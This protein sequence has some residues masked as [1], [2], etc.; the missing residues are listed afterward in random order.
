VN[1]KAQNGKNENN[2][3]VFTWY[4][5]IIVSITGPIFIQNVNTYQYVIDINAI[6][7]TLIVLRVTICLFSL[8]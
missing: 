8:R 7:L 6:T 4:L 2:T 3:Y 5:I 1:H